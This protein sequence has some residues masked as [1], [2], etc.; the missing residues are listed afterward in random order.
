MQKRERVRMLIGVVLTIALLVVLLIRN[1]V[2]VFDRSGVRRGEGVYWNGV[3]YVPASGQYSE[4]KTIAKT[5]DGWQ[6]N[7]VEEDDTHTFVVMRSFLDNCLLVREDYDI[8]SSGEITTI[9]WNGKYI[10]DDGFK[11]AV[12]EVISRAKPDFEYVT[13]GIF[14]LKDNQKMRLLHV[15]YDGCPLA[16][17]YVGYMGTV[18]GKWYLTVNLPDGESG[19]VSCYTIPEKYTDILNRYFS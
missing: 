6:I 13:E 3:L 7:E 19:S 12:T 14:Q 10:A 15:G 11:Q 1:G 16:T 8:P 18:E 17:G 2:I 9:S 5:N 4:G